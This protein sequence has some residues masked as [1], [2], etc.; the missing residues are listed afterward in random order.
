MPS[1]GSPATGATGQTQEHL[2]ISAGPSAPA[3][4]FPQ[5][6]P[7]TPGKLRE[8]TLPSY[9]PE[10]GLQSLHFAFITNSSVHSTF[11]AMQTLWQNPQEHCSSLSHHPNYF[12]PET[13]MMSGLGQVP[14][15]LALSDVSREMVRIY[16][17][18]ESDSLAH[19]AQ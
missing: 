5:C 1:A 16:K 3:P 18:A 9:V 10:A 19:L 7:G 6:Q 13:L 12:G 17:S 8:E 4:H 11:K 15:L 2:E 14:E